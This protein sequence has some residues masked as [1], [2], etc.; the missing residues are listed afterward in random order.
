MD[1]V[2]SLT[3]ITKKY[4]DF[5][6]VDQLSLSIYQGEIFGLLGPNGSGKT[7]CVKI[8]CGL[9]PPTLGRATVLQ[10]DVH[11]H[12]EEIRSRLGY[13]P[14]RFGLY[15]DLTVR[16]N[17]LFLAGLYGLPN[18]IARKRVA[19]LTDDLNLGEMQ[20]RH[21][22]TLSAGW[23]RRLALAAAVVHQPKLLLLDEP[24]SGVDP[25]VRRQFW[26]YLHRLAQNGTTILITTHHLDEAEYCHRVAILH[27]GRLLACG[28]PSKLKEAIQ[29]ELWEVST[30][31]W[32]E[33]YLKIRGRF[34]HYLH[35]K[36]IRV[37]LRSG[38]AIGAL[39][40]LLPPDAGLTL[41]A[42]EL[43]DVFLHLAGKPNP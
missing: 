2:I 13:M 7:T 31:V 37:W 16:E 36:K 17:L 26:E 22:S 27:H 21:V 28:T 18:E 19:E 12:G 24:T 40:A 39:Q 6:A 9:V 30:S 23:K 34:E 4:G 20:G 35:G 41:I 42:P 14:Q 32:T 38:Q 10:R 33:T 1:E 43:E 3:G 8:M 5:T 11:R 25:L 15:E 29:G